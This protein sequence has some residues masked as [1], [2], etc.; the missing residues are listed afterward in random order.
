MAEI[1]TVQELDLD[2]PF[3]VEGMPG[4]GLVGQIIVDHLD[5]SFGMSYH[6]VV[7]C[8][9]L[10]QVAIFEGGVHGVRPPVRLH[11]DEEN[12]LVVL[13]SDVPVSPNAEGF[14]NCLLGW[15][16]EVDATPL[17]VSGLPQRAE[18]VPSLY[19]VSTGDG[20]DLLSDIEAPDSGGVVSGPTGALLKEAGDRE[21]DAVGLIVEADPQFPDP[22]ASRVVVEKGV[23]P[24]TGVDVDTSALVE[25][26]EEIMEKKEEL[27]KKMQAEE[28]ESSTA[29]PTG[30]Y[31]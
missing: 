23:A 14:A 20:D 1:R 19:G 31:R 3:V 29:T 25:K 5:D 11:A 8:D 17:F 4:V 15:M 7:D 28:E 16:E 18:G 24:I 9:S 12:D 30:M 22:A 27:A 10:P 6:A 26:S 21:M 2:S 13:K